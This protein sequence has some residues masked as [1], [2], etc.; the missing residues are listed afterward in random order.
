MI[1]RTR[2][3]RVCFYL[4]SVDDYMFYT[5]MGLAGTTVVMWCYVWVW[6]WEWQVD[7]SAL[8]LVFSISFWSPHTQPMYD[9]WTICL[10]LPSLSLFL[11]LTASCCSCVILHSF[12]RIGFGP[13]RN[14]YLPSNCT[15]GKLELMWQ[16]HIHCKTV[17]SGTLLEGGLEASQVRT[18]IF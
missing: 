1:D 16:R 12:K 18:E 5:W 4:L 3:T 15:Q 9:I 6:S 11:S 2:H 7:V 14:L 10:N 13:N 8:L 17:G